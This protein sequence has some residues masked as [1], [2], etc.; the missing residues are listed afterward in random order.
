M[1]VWHVTYSPLRLSWSTRGR[2]GE[3][4]PDTYPQPPDT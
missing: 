3:A 4:T 1:A 2:L